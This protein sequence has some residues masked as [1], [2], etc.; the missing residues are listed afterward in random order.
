LALPLL[1]WWS[2]CLTGGIRPPSG[3]EPIVLA[4]EV[5]G[6]CNCGACCSWERS[7]LGLGPA[8]VSS[9]PNKGRPKTVGVTASGTRA[10]RGTVA[11]DTS[12]LPFGAI[13]YVPGYG[14]G[15]VEDRGGKIKGRCLDLWY[16]SHAEAQAWGRKR[17][18]VRVWMP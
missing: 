11:A 1:V 12:V 14:Y 2:G 15:R 13:V 17:M 8:V 5:T 3:R 4:M 9:G 6:Y 16:P 18:N 7:W 10:A